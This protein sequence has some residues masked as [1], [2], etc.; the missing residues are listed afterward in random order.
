MTSF[1]IVGKPCSGK[2]TARRILELEGFRGFEASAYARARCEM[3]G[4]DITSVFERHGRDIVAKDILAALQEEDDVVISG[5]RTLEEVAALRCAH[6]STL[7]A[8]KASDDICFRRAV[9]RGRESYTSLH[10]YLASR[11]V[12][13]LGLGLA[14]TLAAANITVVNQGS[15]R[16]FSEA[17]RSALLEGHRA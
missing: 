10:D 9:Q 8:I 15:L 2:T 1:L 4:R 11:L 13:D 17:I 7:V 3:E 16:E 6:Q 14:D 5:F 12:P